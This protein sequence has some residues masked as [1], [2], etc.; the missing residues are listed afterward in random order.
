VLINSAISVARDSADGPEADEEADLR[1]KE[2]M[3]WPVV[4]EE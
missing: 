2:V 4:D 3:M 1:R